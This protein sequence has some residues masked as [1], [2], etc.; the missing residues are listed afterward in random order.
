MKRCKKTAIALFAAFCLSL[1]SGC[2]YLPPE[3]PQDFDAFIESLPQELIEDSDY[4]LNLLYENPEAAGFSQEVLYELPFTSIE[5]YKE[6]LSEDDLL[7]QLES[8]SYNSLTEKQ[9]LTYDILKDYLTR[10]DIPEELVPLDNNYLGS[11][12]SFQA[13]LPL[14]LNEY[15]IRTQHDLD[16]YFHMIV[17]Y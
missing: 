6:S 14:L 5:E 2:L 11:F 4:S 16:S 13:E 15:K 9:K 12:T 1:F 3:P 17:S 8:F 7:E 10:M